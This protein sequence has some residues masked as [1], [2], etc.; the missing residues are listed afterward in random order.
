MS[1]SETIDKVIARVGDLPAMP[2][3][4]GEVLDLMEQP[5]TTMADLSTRIQHDPALTAK[6]LRVSNSPYYGMRQYV[7]TLKLA[8]VILGMREVRNIVVG[9]AVVD[10]LRDEKTDV[11]LADDFWNHSMMTAAVARKLGNGMRL[12]LQG[13][14]FVAGLLHDIGKMILARQLGPAYEA[15]YR[16]H[17]EGYEDLI[18]AEERELGFNHCDAAAA[19]ATKWNL[20]KTL[21]DALY[22]HHPSHE[23]P[24]KDAKNPLLAAVVRVAERAARHDFDEG[25]EDGCRALQDLE[26]WQMLEEA[27]Q[28]IDFESRYAALTE[29]IEEF[30]DSPRLEL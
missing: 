9:I 11:L 25:T 17:S 19:L 22:Y 23:R 5:D 16:A 1:F 10:T 24:L 13:E 30:K 3:V 6:I 28:P 21:C 2:A 7:G 14:D 12:N 18:E 8:L 15:I 20:P 29:A 4:V 27:P 26:A